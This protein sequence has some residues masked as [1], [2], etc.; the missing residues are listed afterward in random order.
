MSLPEQHFVNGNSRTFNG[1]SCTGPTQ[2]R[3]DITCAALLEPK[4]CNKY[5]AVQLLAV[6]AWWPSDGGRAR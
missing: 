5:T 4:A 2:D 1:M 6:A 3:Y